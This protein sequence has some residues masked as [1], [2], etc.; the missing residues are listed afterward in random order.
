[1]GLLVRVHLLT[2]CEMDAGLDAE[3]IFRQRVRDCLWNGTER[4]GSDVFDEMVARISVA[5]C[6]LLSD[7][8]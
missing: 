7:T 2:G 8:Y 1:M 5:Q 3:D 4:S 6:Y